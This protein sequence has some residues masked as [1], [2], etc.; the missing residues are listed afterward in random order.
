MLVPCLLAFIFGWLAFRS[1]VTGVYLSILTQA[2]TL[3]LAL[4]LFQNDIDLVRHNH[5]KNAGLRDW[6]NGI[7]LVNGPVYLQMDLS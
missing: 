4:Y 2:M 5:T 6:F 1:R 7:T 3:A